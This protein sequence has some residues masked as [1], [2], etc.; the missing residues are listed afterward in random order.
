MDQSVKI[1]TKDRLTIRRPI[2]WNF[3]R[4]EKVIPIAA[5]AINS[6]KPAKPVVIDRLAA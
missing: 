1:A 2:V 5:M 3:I 6:A 4:T